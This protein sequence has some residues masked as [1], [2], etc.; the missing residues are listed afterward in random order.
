LPS[1]DYLGIQATRTSKN[2]LKN[3]RAQQ[4]CVF[5]QCVAHEHHHPKG[6]SIKMQMM[7]WLHSKYHDD[8]DLNL[9]LAVYNLELNS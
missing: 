7:K 3:M 6:V 1:G 8:D 4:T 2:V 9:E 5:A